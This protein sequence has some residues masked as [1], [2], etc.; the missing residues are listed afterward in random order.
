[1]SQSQLLSSLRSLL[2][3]NGVPAQLNAE[4]TEITLTDMLGADQNFVFGS[5]DTGF[6]VQG[7]LE[8]VPAPAGAAVLAALGLMQFRRRR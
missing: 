3:S 7:Q 6:A 5:S 1:M 2:N 4:Q 8:V